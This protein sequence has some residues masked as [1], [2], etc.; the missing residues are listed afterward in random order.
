[1]D[2]A[3]ALA[4]TIPILILLVL[5]MGRLNLLY[6]LVKG[7]VL[8]GVGYLLV[9]LAASLLMPELAEKM[10]QPLQALWDLAITFMR[11]LGA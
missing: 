9:V 7:V 6:K 5:L 11:E 8:V 1:M 10:L 4:L 3:T 2:A